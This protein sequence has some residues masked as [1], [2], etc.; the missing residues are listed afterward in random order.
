MYIYVYSTRTRFLS[1]PTFQRDKQASH[2]NP[3]APWL[4]SLPKGGHIQ[5]SLAIPKALGPSIKKEMK[6]VSWN[7]RIKEGFHG[8]N[9]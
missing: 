6:E 7:R 2:P 9:K 1:P 4:G 3:A 5:A 8:K